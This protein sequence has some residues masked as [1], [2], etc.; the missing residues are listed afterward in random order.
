MDWL[1]YIGN[2]IKVLGWRGHIT[3]NTETNNYYPSFIQ[4]LD[5]L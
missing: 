5:K 2:A 3:E 1:F 4:E